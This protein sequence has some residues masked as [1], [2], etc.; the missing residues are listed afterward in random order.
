MWNQSTPSNPISRRLIFNIILPSTPSALF[1]NF[2]YTHV[3]YMLRPS[4]PPWFDLPNNISWPVQFINANY[5]L[6]KVLDSEVSVPGIANGS[7]YQFEF[8]CT[9]LEIQ[10]FLHTFWAF[11]LVY[12]RLVQARWK[13]NKC[14][15]F[16]I[17]ASEN[18][19][20]FCC[21]C[22]YYYYYYY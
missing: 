21:C 7:P 5:L 20:R 10:L 4:Y 19:K 2:S 13:F 15:H 6:V 3:C 8:F 18:N 22:Y 17:W 11:Q 16:E 14:L 1:I 12:W 9:S